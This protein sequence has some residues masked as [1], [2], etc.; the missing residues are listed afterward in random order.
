MV[1]TLRKLV[2]SFLNKTPRFHP[3]RDGSGKSEIGH[4]GAALLRI[5]PKCNGMALT[6]Q[7]GPEYGNMDWKL[8]AL[9]R[10]G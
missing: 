5:V 1:Q 3:T 2:G 7:N 10:Y 8:E 9:D 4:I 6:Q